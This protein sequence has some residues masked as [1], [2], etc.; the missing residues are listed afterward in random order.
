MSSHPAARPGPGSDQRSDRTS[1]PGGRPVTDGTS[2]RPPGPGL[3]EGSGEGPRRAADGPEGGGREQGGRDLGG[4]DPAPGSAAEQPWSRQ[5]L[6]S[7]NEWLLLER[8]RTTGAASRAQLARD[9]GL[10]KPTVSAALATLEQAGLAREAGLLAPGRGR[11]AVLYE[12]DPTAGYVLGVDIGRGRLRVAVADLAGEITARRDV[13]N[14]GSTAGAVADAVIAEARAAIAEAGIGPGAVVHAAI[15]T[16]GVWDETEQRV[17]YAAQ[18]PGWG[19][20]G[21]FDRIRAGLDTTISVHNDANLAALGEYARGAGAGS[22]HFV[23]LLLGTGIGMGVVSGGKLQRGA[24]GAAG[25]IGFLPLPG[26]PGA[27]AG[28]GQGADQGPGQSPGQGGDEG[29]DH[30]QRPGMLESAASA[31]SV[32]RSAKELGVRGAATAKQVFDAARAG[33]PAALAAV[34]RQA[35]Q[36]AY[37]VAVVSS[38]IDPDLV[39]LGGGMG[40]SSDLL[41]DRVEEAL[42][43]LTPLRPRLAPSLLGDEAVLIGALSTA[44]RTARPEVFDR[45]SAAVARA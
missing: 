8:L 31:E 28:G 24:H 6:R 16:P 15:G 39:V 25:E 42:H 45:R 32:V 2:G 38:V 44:L 43:A 35:E 7:N 36:L 21:L 18:L 26:V 10:S 20:R 33:D 14:R 13:P 40:Q 4:P 1:G 3:G 12:P 11:V 5:R 29:G 34:Q 9:T 22:R 27:G 17:R 30:D 23:Y 37:A 19:R 41:L